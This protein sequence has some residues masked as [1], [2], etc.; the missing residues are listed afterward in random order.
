LAGEARRRRGEIYC[1][2]EE[3]EG[4]DCVAELKEDEKA[5]HQEFDVWFGFGG[6]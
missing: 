6:W 2:E 1:K 5:G 4:F 3:A